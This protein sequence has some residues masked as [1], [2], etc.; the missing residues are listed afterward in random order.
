MKWWNPFAKRGVPQDAEEELRRGRTLY[1]AWLAV[2][3]SQAF[4]VL[5]EEIG[6]QLRSQM[7]QV[8]ASTLP[9]ADYAR[10][11]GRIEMLLWMADLPTSR[12][13]H[14]DE[15]VRQAAE[16]ESLKRGPWVDV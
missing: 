8:A 11:T 2:E 14:Y 9:Q 10:I 12:K 3:K 1:E 7:N 6:D 13:N 15:M 5:R 16:G 4:A